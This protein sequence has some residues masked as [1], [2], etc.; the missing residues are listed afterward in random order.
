[1]EIN[2]YRKSSQMLVSAERGKPEYPEKNLLV[3]SREPTNS[4]HIIMM[5]SLGIESGHIGGKRV[6]SPLRHPCTPKLFNLVEKKQW[7]RMFCSCFPLKKRQNIQ[8][9]LCHVMS[10][11]V[12][13][14]S[15]EDKKQERAWG[16][17]Y[18]CS[19]ERPV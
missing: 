4:T 15:L 1:M 19:N 16:K 13:P 10:Q 3:Q 9:V 11:M 17:R 2:N 14:Y 18:S 5:P 8:N 6:L 12:F 7:C